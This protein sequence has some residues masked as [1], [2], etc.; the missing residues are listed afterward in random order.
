MVS[1]A[2]EKLYLVAAEKGDKKAMKYALEYCKGL[3]VNCTD[4]NGR[5]ALVIAIQNGNTDIIKL[6][7]AFHVDLGD[8]LLRAVDMQIKQMVDLICEYIKKKKRKDA[9]NCRSMNEDFHPDVTP[10]ILAAHHNNYEII[11]ILLECGAEIKDPET[12]EFQSEEYTLE[13][14]LGTVNIYK[15]LASEA[16]ISLTSKDPVNTAFELSCKLRELSERDYEF[17]FQY[18]DLAHQCEVFGANIIQFVRD[19]REQNTVLCTDP[20]E[21]MAV[22]TVDEEM[23]YKVKSAIRYGQKL[24]VT[25]PNCQQLLIEKWYHGLPDWRQQNMLRAFFLTFILGISFPVFSL[26]YIILPNHSFSRLLKIPFVKFLC[27]TASALTFL[28]ILGMQTINFKSGVS[29]EDSANRKLLDRIIEDSKNASFN[30]QEWLIVFWVIGMTWEEVSSILKNGSRGI[31]ENLQMKM[32][33]YSTLLLFWAWISLRVVL[34]FEAM[35]QEGQPSDEEMAIS[36]ADIVSRAF[37]AV[38][39]VF[40]FLRLIRITVLSLQLGPLQISLG[41]M[42]EDI[43]KFMMIFCL[44]WVAFSVGLNQLYWY[45]ALNAEI[46]CNRTREIGDDTSCLQPFATMGE[47]MNTLFW[48]IFGVTKLESLNVEGRD[49][50][51]VEGVGQTLYGAY[52]VIGIIVL[53]NILIAMMT[54]TYTKI[55]E[56]ADIQWKYSRS[57]LWMSYFGESAA[58]PPPFN[59]IPSRLSLQNCFNRLRQGLCKV[60]DQMTSQRQSVIEVKLKEYEEVVQ[61]AVKR[62]HFEKQRDEEEE[63]DPW[64]LQ[65]KQDI[66][67]FKYDM[68]EA[69][70]EMDNKINHVQ[71]KVEDRDVVESR[72]GPGS[73]MFHLLQDAVQS[74]PL[75]RYASLQFIDEGEEEQIQ[76]RGSRFTLSSIQSP[77]TATGLSEPVS[78]APSYPII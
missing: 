22:D 32:L 62:Y 70:G 21:I 71:A 45:H 54:K 42:F 33:D 5:T 6:L 59:L 64:L 49:R 47:T 12:Y 9:L 27:N 53:L 8:A 52:H 3:N 15:A 1:S 51:F 31:T 10:I 28:L 56:D 38:A 50:W 4:A 2:V 35:Q 18:A 34:N 29:G 67:G 46:R 14:S 72:G 66:S 40:S 57:E 65:L 36:Y 60:P 41:R 68:F 19:S 48:A 26:A 13:H 43:F 16:Y 77:S 74:E 55:E 61:D 63:A 69:L 73:E 25:H 23:P 7:L 30:I 44:V 11:K 78:R 76:D 39:K 37:F 20:A 75:D 58:L 17:R 24:F